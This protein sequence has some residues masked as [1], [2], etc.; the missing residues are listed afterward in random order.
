[1]KTQTYSF[2]LA[3]LALSLSGCVSTTDPNAPLSA[4][5]T[6]PMGP[7]QHMVSCVDKPAYCADLA[8]NLCPK[9]FDVTSNV[10]NEADHGRMT[11]II[12]C[13]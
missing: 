13:Y 3:V 9:G 6:S 12:K 1:M 4:V 2:I 10:V 7:E 11:M 8:N 5:R